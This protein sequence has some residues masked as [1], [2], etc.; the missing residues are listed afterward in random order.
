MQINKVEIQSNYSTYAAKTIKFNFF[1]K[2]KNI[3]FWQ[4]VLAALYSTIYQFY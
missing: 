3:F 1:L 2:G 4:R